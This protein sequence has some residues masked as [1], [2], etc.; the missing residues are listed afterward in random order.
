MRGMNARIHTEADLQRHIHGL[1]GRDPRF[2]PIADAVNDVPLRRLPGGL[3][4][5][6]RIVMGQQLSVHAAAAVW[7][8]LEALAAPVCGTTLCALSDEALREAG[9]SRQKVKT[10]RAVVASGIETTLADP[11]ADD[12]ALRE[13]LLAVPGI[14]PWTADLYLIVCTGAP[15]ILP[16]GD[17]ALRRAA[18]RAL[19][20]ANEPTIAA[21][22]EIA[23]AWAPHRATAARLL[24]A[25]YRLPKDTASTRPRAA[26]VDDRAPV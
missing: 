5:L 10:L 2:G 22:D 3:P 6:L 9:L 25:Y 15:D 14:G 16:A 20:L 21:L 19:N 8:R 17:L 7:S 12:A 4:G 1:V 13:T 26:S 23:A 18:A 11:P 24:W